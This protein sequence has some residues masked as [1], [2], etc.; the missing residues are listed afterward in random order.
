[1]QGVGR[2]EDGGVEGGCA[3]LHRVVREDVAMQMEGDERLAR[4]RR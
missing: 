4:G 2:N 3:V 1:M